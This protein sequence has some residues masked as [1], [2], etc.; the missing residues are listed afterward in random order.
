[1]KAAHVMVSDSDA[2][3]LYGKA[4]KG[5]RV[6]AHCVEELFRPTEEIVE[7]RHPVSLLGFGT[8]H[9][10]SK[11][12]SQLETLEGWR[13]QDTVIRNIYTR[14]S[15]SKI[16][17]PHRLRRAFRTFDVDREGQVRIVS[18]PFFRMGDAGV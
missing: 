15:E 6:T 12:G 5:G 1:M 2:R 3:E 11:L 17:N 7:P 16:G 4:G 10:F 14:I 8:G 18:N 9:T 13:T